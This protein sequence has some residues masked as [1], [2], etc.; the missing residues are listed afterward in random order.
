MPIKRLDENPTISDDIV[1]SIETP[2][3]EGCLSSNPYK[4]DR[5]VIYYVQR[6]YTGNN[7]S[8]YDKKFINED[9]KTQLDAA[10]AKA[11]DTPSA[12]NLADVERL[13]AT[14][15]SSTLTETFYYTDAKTVAIF[16]DDANP[17][18]LSTES[19]AG[20]NRLVNVSEDEDGNAQF[21]I[22]ELDWSPVGL[23]EGDYFVCWTWKP[24][25][26]GDS[27]SEIKHFTLQ[28]STQVTTSIPSHFT[29]PDKYDTLMERYLPEMFK[30]HLGTSDLTPE[31][32][33]EFNKAVGKGFS[34][35]EDMTNQIV[36][37]IDANAT[38]EAFLPL[39]ADLYR[40]K[41][42]SGDPTLWRR[43]IKNAI[44]LYK[45]KGTYSG[46][47]E[48]LDQIGVKLTR[49]ARLWQVV[50]KYTYQEVFVVD[51]EDFFILSKKAIL[52]I[53]TD[54]FEL[55]HRPVG[56]TSWTTLDSTYVELDDYEETTVMTWVDSNPLLQGDEIRVVYQITTVPSVGEQTIEDYIRVL[57]LADQRDELEHEYPLKNWNVRVIE[58]DDPLIDMV[59][60]TRHPYYNSIMYGKIRTEF[61][62]SENIYN[63]EEYNGSTRDSYDPC[64]IDK[65]FID[66]CSSCLGSKFVV[67]LEI[68]KLSH[69]RILEAQDTIEGFVPFH[70]ILHSLNLTG[71]HNEL[72]QSPVEELDI[73]IQF[74]NG[75]FAI[76]G[77]A[78]T[79]FNRSMEQGEEFKRDELTNMTTAVSSGSGSGYN[80]NIVLYAPVNQLDRLPLDTDPDYNYLEVLSPSINA[81]VYSLQDAMQNHATIVGSPTEPLDQSA[82]TFRL[83]NERLSQSVANIYQ[84]D[85]FKLQDANV[86]F[87]KLAIKTQWDVANNVDPV[88]TGDPWTI[89]IAAYSDTYEIINIL[90][91]GSLLL[92]DPSK[93]L[94]TSNTNNIN[95]ILKTDL[96]DIVH[97]GTT[98][99]LKVK[100]RGLVDLGVSVDIRGNTVT[101]SDVRELLD[102][103][104]GNGQNH[105]I[106]YDGSQYAFDG[107]VDGETSQI[108]IA[109]YT[110]GDVAGTSI[111]LYQRIVDN[112]KGY[113]A[114]QG[115][116][117]ITVDNYETDL[118]ICNGENAGALFPAMDASGHSYTLQLENN[119]FYQNYIVLINTNYYAISKIDNNVIWLL[120]PDQNW[121]TLGTALTFDILKYEKLPAS[122]TERA[123]PP[124]QGMD[125]DL[126]DRRG[127]EVITNVIATDPPASLFA[128]S[129]E[130]WMPEDMPLVEGSKFAIRVG[131]EDV[132]TSLIAAG[133]NAAGHD[134]IVE[135]ITQNEGI[136][137]S[138]KVK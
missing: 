65:D 138:I 73:L 51:Q 47:S 3:A 64:D 55:Y 86:D 74:V 84:D 119:T 36:D 82:F 104:H 121:T 131:H 110:D 124:T 56:E 42:K 128:L 72:I 25:P 59:I 103:Y 115:I 41:L 27:L 28:G 52:P 61:P 113:F 109:D 127:N 15:D 50:S 89:T 77:N 83:S 123:Y 43:Q 58:E 26:S 2:D 38:G 136:T 20:N 116:K 46:L 40:L 54:N 96:G 67:D 132:P 62:Y 87:W 111:K 14:L 32:L 88:Y 71:S 60:T 137:F 90:T 21:G 13:S 76:A 94:P 91:D 117:L 107:F 49:F 108:Y 85:V 57:P 129:A 114:Y 53:D 18:W 105:Y 118:G 69:D 79:I 92:Y 133:L 99:A 98:G 112:A 63:M 4:V 10:I 34:F 31:V 48:A 44:P 135:S 8:K 134:Q 102:S 97:S 35:L 70:S 22:F 95:Y 11:C 80:E 12:D 16:G 23:R 66:Q 30:T 33:Q 78:Q 100:R 1:I 106:K 68:E 93:T 6:D 126:L 39:L 125:F 101:L 45:K 81:G 29:D 122:V 9:I 5:V 19:I 75:E 120:G 37:L 24:N 130:E 7:Y 17:A